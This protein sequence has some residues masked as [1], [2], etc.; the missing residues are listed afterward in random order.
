MHKAAGIY[1]LLIGIAV[2]SIIFNHSASAQGEYF[3]E[4]WRW[5]H[6]T[7]ESG[8]PSNIIF[9][10]RETPGGTPWV[11]TPKGYAWY[12]GHQWVPAP[13]FLGN[14]DPGGVLF[15]TASETM[16]VHSL[17]KCYWLTTTGVQTIWLPRDIDE[18]FPLSHDTIFLRINDSSFLGVAGRIIPF[19]L[20]DPPPVT[21]IHQTTNGRFWTISRNGLYHM[22]GSNW[23]LKM[24]SRVIFCGTFN[25]GVAENKHGTGLFSFSVPAEERGLWEWYNHSTPNRSKSEKFNL[26]RAYDVGPNDEAIVMYETRAVRFRRGGIWM[27]ATGIENRIRGITKVRFRENGDIWFATL[28]GLYLYRSSFSMW[29]YLTHPSPDLRNSV[30][31]IIHTRDSSLWVASSDGVEVY[32]RDG[33]YRHTTIIQNIPLYGVNGLAEDAEGNVWITSGSTFP[34]AFRWDGNH[35]THFR[36]VHDTS[37]VYIHK[38]RK[39]RHG[40]LWFLGIGISDPRFHQLQPGVFLLLSGRFISITTKDGLINNRVYDMVESNDGALWF[41]TFGG[42]SKCMPGSQ[43]AQALMNNA[44]STFDDSRITYGTWQHWTSFPGIKYNQIYTLALNQNNRV[45][46]AHGYRSRQ[47]TAVGYIDTDDSVRYFSTENGP[48]NQFVMDLNT[49]EKGHLWLATMDGIYSYDGVNFTTYDE[50]SGLYPVML[51]AVYPSGSDL[52]VATQGK[53]VAILHSSEPLTPPPKVFIE[54]AIYEYHT[55]ALR[56][57]PLAYYGEISSNDILTRFR[58]DED[59]WSGWSVNHQVIYEEMKPGTHRIDVQA[60]GA[61]GN[62]NPVPATMI[63]TVPMPWYF[64][65]V[66]YIPSGVVVLTLF[67]L[68]GLLIRRKQLY[69]LSIQ[70]SE[71]KFRAVCETTSSAIIIYSDS[72]ILFANPGAVQLTGYSRDELYGKILFDIVHEDDRNTMR[73]QDHGRTETPATARHDEFRIRTK[74][75]EE[76][77]LDFTSGWIHYQGM[78]VKLGTAFDITERKRYEMQILTDQEQLRSLTSDLSRTEDRE[79]RRLAIQLHD[80]IGQTLMFLKMKLRLLQ[81]SHTDEELGEELEALRFTVEQSITETRTLMYELSP[82]ILY[83]LGLKAAIEWLIGEMGSKYG[84]NISLEDDDTPKLIS[85]DVRIFLFNAIR[86]SLVNVIKHAKAKHIIISL[87]L[88]D[89]YLQV[90]V[91][92]DG[93]GFNVLRLNR[94]AGREGGFGLLSVRERALRFGGSFSIESDPGKGTRVTI[95]VPLLTSQ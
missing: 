68:I 49:D 51:N 95:T 73:E 38:I 12:N 83:E 76:R 54:P 66:F 67:T 82:P 6:F 92:D 77:W 87:R 45:W 78:T 70:T 53:G 33:S 79:R 89:P 19:T 5:V 16:F 34:G 43:F 10:I 93:I 20:K 63:F 94:E 36:L 35:W 80:T 1:I 72:S 25:S 58:L 90:S 46:F 24:S 2:H 40:N 75:G 42:I 18:A 4:D 84:L 21:T 81:R 26:I 56:W 65:P 15:S 60:K 88:A 50:H 47:L 39:D 37:K 9:E 27:S 86:E 23:K 52:Y 62:F 31:E 13:S 28:N 74:E 85:D 44:N 32:R 48:A 55:I 30:N 8:L 64:Q 69:N 59:L 61:Y 11:N 41:A 29:S 22:D 71:A 91:K 7:T 3:D 57:K 14:N 17:G